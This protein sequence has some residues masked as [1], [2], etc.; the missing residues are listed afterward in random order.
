MSTATQRGVD[1]LILQ[2]HREVETL[3]A[4]VDTEERHRIKVARST[5]NLVTGPA[6]SLIARTRDAMDSERP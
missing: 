6:A 2:D 3:F 1:E 4:T 5:G